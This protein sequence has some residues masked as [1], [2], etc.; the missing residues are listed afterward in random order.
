MKAKEFY[1]K[2]NELDETHLN[3]PIKVASSHGDIDV[4]EVA[5]VAGDVDGYHTCIYPAI[6]LVPK[7]GEMSAP[8]KFLEEQRG[9]LAEQYGQEKHLLEVEARLKGIRDNSGGK[10]Q[11]DRLFVS[12]LKLERRYLKEEI[13]LLG[14]IYKL[15][16]PKK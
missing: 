1:E 4:D 14:E 15:N 13:R 3:L 5:F 8:R 10:T 9:V 16:N 11:I 6:E 2:F 7:G 12:K